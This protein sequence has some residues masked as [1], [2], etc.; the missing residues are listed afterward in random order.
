MD[1]TYRE[2]FIVKFH[3]VDFRG[4]IKLFTIMDYIQ[5]TAEA[6]GTSIGLGFENMM[7]HGL[8]WVV[9]RM[10]LNMERYPGAYEEI[11]V[12]TELAGCEKL[13]C[14]RRFTIL[15][16]NEN[17]IGNA[18]LYYLMLDVITKFPQKPKVC[19][20][21]IANLGV[22]NRG[23]E[24]LKKL[25]MPDEIVQVMDRKLYYNEIDANQHVNNARYVSFVEDCFSLEW[26]KNHEISR[27]QINYVKEIKAEDSLKINRFI[28]D[29]ERNTYFINGTDEVKSQ[30]FFQCKVT[31]R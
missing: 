28:D 23:N 30:E 5:H 3:E 2:K 18:V 1:I 14:V 16:G 11:I 4:K 8:F 27:V 25:K 24:S 7:N 12:E 13:F 20:I 31:Y 15:D 29:N 26:H 17:I 10:Q 21:D 19:P 9:S 22:E 6:H